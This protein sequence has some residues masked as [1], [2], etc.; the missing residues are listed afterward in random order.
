M[1]LP[2]FGVSSRFQSSYWISYRKGWSVRRNI[3]TED[4][5]KSRRG[6][7]LPSPTTD[8][9]QVFLLLPHPRFWLLLFRPCF[10]PWLAFFP[11]FHKQA[12][13]LALTGFLTPYWWP[14][15]L[16]DYDS[17]NRPFLSSRARICYLQQKSSSLVS[18]WWWLGQWLSDYELK[19]PVTW[20]G[21]SE[22]ESLED[23]EPHLNLRSP[24]KTDNV[25]R[26]FINANSRIPE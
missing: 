25:T 22:L 21:I 4:F 23:A 6:S 3:L 2:F 16:V 5:R 13:R 26:S 10:D 19:D 12:Q 1:F 15:F 11:S 8:H 24:T 9:G 17:Q 20:S 7:A 18:L 14:P